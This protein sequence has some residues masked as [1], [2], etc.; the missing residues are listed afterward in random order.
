M[1]KQPSLDRKK[2][3]EHE[4]DLSQ[5]SIKDVEVATERLAEIYTLQGLDSKAIEIYE[6]LILKF[7]EKRAY[8]AEKIENIKNKD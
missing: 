8:F 6:K 7:P 5:Q 1:V 2:E 3:P 4:E